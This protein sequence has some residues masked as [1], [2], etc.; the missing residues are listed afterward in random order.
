MLHVYKKLLTIL[1]RGEKPADLRFA[2]LAPVQENVGSD[3]FVEIL[4]HGI[5]Y[6]GRS[7]A[8]PESIRNSDGE[9]EAGLG[10]YATLTSVG[11]SVGA[12]GWISG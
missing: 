11:I 4:L 10:W 7:F 3:A 2:N 5:A 1:S 8:Q 9:D 6:G 12:S